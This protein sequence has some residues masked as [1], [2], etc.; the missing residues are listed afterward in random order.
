LGFLIII[1]NALSQ[2]ELPFI[3]QANIIKL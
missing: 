3:Q 1:F 2:K